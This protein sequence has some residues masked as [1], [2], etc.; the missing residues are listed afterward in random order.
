MTVTGAI[1]VEDGIVLFFVVI[2]VE[3]LDF[4]CCKIA[5]R[6]HT[7]VELTGYF[8]E[9]DVGYADEMEEWFFLAIVTR[10]SNSTTV[11]SKSWELIN[12]PRR[13]IEQQKKDIYLRGTFA[14]LLKVERV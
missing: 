12:N 11:V 10:S 1:F 5:G 14:D 2:E 7:G 13:S 9:G 4:G 3:V 6:D 8:V